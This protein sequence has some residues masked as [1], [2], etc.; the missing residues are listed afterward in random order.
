MRRIRESIGA[1]IPHGLKIQNNPRIDIYL[2]NQVTKQKIPILTP[3]VH[4]Y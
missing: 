3:I 2:I 4:I 1:L